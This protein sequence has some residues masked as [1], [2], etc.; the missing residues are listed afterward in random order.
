M[1]K[2]LLTSGIAIFGLATPFL[3]MTITPAREALLG[4]APD[5][6]VLALADKIDTDRVDIESE[7]S[8]KDED[9]QKLQS[10]LDAQQ[11][12]LAE[13]QEMIDENNKAVLETKI[14]VK[15]ANDTTDSLAKEQCEAEKKLHC[16]D[17]YLTKKSFDKYLDDFGDDLNSEME[18]DLE[19][20]FDRCQNILKS[21]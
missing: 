21:C 4:L 18:N 20:R 2:I 14:A 11:A 19:K 7:L 9:I 17:K 13:Q 1:K 8:Q 12:K 5:E 3:A 10:T 6:A 15:N 16:S